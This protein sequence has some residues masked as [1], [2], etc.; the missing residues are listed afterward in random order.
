MNEP[1]TT[2]APVPASAPPVVV[3]PPE[4]VAAAPIA[5]TAPV[6]T[7][8]PTE[9]RPVSSNAFASG[10]NMNGA[11]VMTGRPSSRVLAP[12]GGHTSFTLG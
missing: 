11:Q 1:T 10:A 8:L 2:T 7:T 9:T 12:P 3:P 4:V 5:P 6:A